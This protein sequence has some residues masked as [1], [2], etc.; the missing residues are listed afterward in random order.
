[1]QKQ[2]RLER[3]EQD[4]RRR[5]IIKFPHFPLERKKVPLITSEPLPGTGK[6]T[7]TPTTQDKQKQQQQRRIK[8]IVLPVLP[9]LWPKAKL[10]KREKNEANLC[11][12][13]IT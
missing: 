9:F 11:I 3:L 5:S 7:P 10:R 8:N 12:E 6:A 2:R 13:V 1:M 4:Q